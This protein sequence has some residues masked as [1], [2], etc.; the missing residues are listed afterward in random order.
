LF[1]VLQEFTPVNE[2][3][4][5]EVLG[6]FP[7]T[8]SVNVFTAVWK[9]AAKQLHF[10]VYGSSFGILS[11]QIEQ[12]VASKPMYGRNFRSRGCACLTGNILFLSAHHFRIQGCL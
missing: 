8:A 2:A 4:G 10:I 12:G 5:D 1:A 9:R 3:D 11:V 7:Q 6:V